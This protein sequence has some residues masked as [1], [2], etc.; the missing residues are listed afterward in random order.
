MAKSTLHRVSPQD[1]P[2]VTF[3]PEQ[4]RAV[5]EVVDSELL[6]LLCFADILRECEQDDPAN[7]AAY[8]LDAM[9]EQLRHA[10]DRTLQQMVKDGGAA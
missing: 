8:V 5:Y 9:L 7:H 3:T 10:V 4:A 6:P 2:V 1:K